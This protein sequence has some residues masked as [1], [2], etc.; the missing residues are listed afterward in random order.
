MGVKKRVR[1][2]IIYFIGIAIGWLF[3]FL[4]L[5]FDNITISFIG[6]VTGLFSIITLIVMSKIQERKQN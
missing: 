6:F 3:I 1:L 2:S 4:G 5:H